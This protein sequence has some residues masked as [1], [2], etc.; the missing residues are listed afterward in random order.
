MREE[1]RI[2]KSERGWEGW[3]E[4]E[5]G[6]YL[7]P[8]KI[9]QI[10]IRILRFNDAAKPDIAESLE[11]SKRISLQNRNHTQKYFIRLIRGSEGAKFITKNKV[12][13]VLDAG[14]APLCPTMLL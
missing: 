8:W 12:K 3:G 14:R 13:T 1:G 11:L 9:V 5:L 7:D 2:I 4:S 10:R 6:S